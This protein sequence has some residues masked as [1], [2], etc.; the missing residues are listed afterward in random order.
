MQLSVEIS[1]YPLREDYK[2][3]ISDFLDQINALSLPLEIR[4]N[5]M[6]TRIFGDFDDVIAC[7]SQCMKHSMALYG[8][9]IFVCKFLQGDARELEGYD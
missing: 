4:S 6:S 5:N 7:L 3:V 1:L 2:A 9:Q 8:K